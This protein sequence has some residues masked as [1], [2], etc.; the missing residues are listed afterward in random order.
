MS[1]AANSLRVVSVS[2]ALEAE[3][4]VMELLQTTFRTSPSSYTNRETG[5]TR[6]NIYLAKK[7]SLPFVRTRLAPG[8]NRIRD[9]GLNP[10]TGEISIKTIRREDWA[11]S[12]KRHFKPI[13][14]GRELLIKPSWSRRRAC[15]GQSIIVLD[16]GLSFGT[17]QHATTQF[18]LRELV[19][20]RNRNVSQS[21]L[22]IGTGSGILAIAAAKLGFEPVNAFDFD[23][24]AVRTSQANAAGNRIALRVKR[25]DLTKMPLR[26]ARQYDLICANLIYDLLVAEVEKILNRLRPG[27]S[28]ILAGILVS[29]FRDVRKVY[30]EHGMK[31]KVT[32]AENEWQSGRFIFRN[33]A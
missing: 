33:Q 6:V 21:F 5:E 24:E 9:S 3:E 32:R 18:C 30:E 16:P 31:L 17:G 12:W 1:R 13:E 26:S 2:I 22:D 10:G 27:G 7:V 29:Q 8:L 20:C 28:L 15:K 11:E 25:G 4:A 23:P 19:E 14:I